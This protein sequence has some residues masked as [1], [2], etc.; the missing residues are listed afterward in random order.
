[1][2][3]YYSIFTFPCFPFGF[4][5]SMIGYSLCPILLCFVYYFYW[6][7]AYHES[8]T[9]REILTPRHLKFSEQLVFPLSRTLHSFRGG[10]SLVYLHLNTLSSNRD[11]LSRFLERSLGPETHQTW[12]DRINRKEYLNM[13][14][15]PFW[16]LIAL[17]V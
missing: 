6:S 13:N 16:L 9:L 3:I 17:A 15:S 14:H 2:S 10:F 5:S 1:M 12:R 11:W 7:F 8:S 4:C